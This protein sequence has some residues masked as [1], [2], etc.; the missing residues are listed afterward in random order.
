ME[1]FRLLLGKKVILFQAQIF[2]F[3]I[4]A[5]LRHFVKHILFPASSPA[6]AF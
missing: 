6:A 5:I 1:R 4:V 2:L 3:Y